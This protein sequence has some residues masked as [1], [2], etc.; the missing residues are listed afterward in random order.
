MKSIIK[1]VILLMLLC[2]IV[3]IAIADNP[4]ISGKKKRHTPKY[5]AIVSYVINKITPVQ[6]QLR[7]NLTGLVND[8]KDKKSSKTLLILIGIAFMYGLIHALGPGHG[9]VITFSYFLSKESGIRKG[10]LLGNLIAFLQV[11][12]AILIVG[13]IYFVIKKTFLTTFEDIRRIFQLMSYA[14]ISLMGIFL[15]SRYFYKHKKES[16]VKLDSNGSSI[17][18]IAVSI[19][20]V[21]CPAAVIIL[22]FSISVDMLM[23]GVVLSLFMAAGMAFTISC[24]GIF[25]IIARNNIGKIFSKNENVNEKIHMYAG[26]IGAFFIFLLGTVLFV[27]NL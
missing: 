7:K 18:P 6:Y 23:T 11:S 4:L 14:L 2:S 13:V 16:G 5:P 1:T 27:I 3:S 19:G 24:V 21:P 25:S 9:K 12:S 20:V 26:L 10:I 22:L 8:L 15:F 17:V